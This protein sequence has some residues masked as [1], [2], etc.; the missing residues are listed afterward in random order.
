MPRF[1][2]VCIGILV[3]F[4]AAMAGCSRSSLDVETPR[5]A[6]YI[7][8]S[9]SVSGDGTE[10]SPFRN[11]SEVSA[12]NAGYSYLQ[13]RGTIAREQIVITASGTSGS[14]ITLGA[15][16]EGAAPVI[17]G[18][19]V[20]TGWTLH[21]GAIY[22][23][24]MTLNSGEGLGMVAQDGTMITRQEWNTDVATTFAAAAAGSYSYDPATNT[25]YIWC[26]GVADPASHTIEISRRLF[27]VRGV[28]VSYINVENLH[29]RYT[30]LHGIVF[31]NGTHINVSGCTVE[32]LGGA[33]IV[34]SP[35]L[36]AGN[37]IEFGNSSAHCTVTGCAI[38]DIFDSGISPQTYSSNHHASD[39]T[40]SDSTISRCGFAGVEIAVLYNG[41]MVNS[42]IDGVIVRNVTVLDSGKGWSGRRYGVE[43]RGIKINADLVAGDSTRG[44]SGVVVE[45]STVSGSAGEG[46]FI[47]GRAGMVT[48]RRCTVRDNGGIGVL[49]QESLITNLLLDLYSSVIR[50]NGTAPHGCGVAYNVPAGQGIVV[51]QNSFYDNNNIGLNIWSHD[52]EARIMNN[53]FHASAYRTHLLVNDDI[54]AT[55][56]IS[57]NCF[58]EFGAGQPIFNY[59]GSTYDTVAA[60]DTA[61]SA[62]AAGDIGTS[63]PLLNAD[64]TIQGMGSPCYHAGNAAAGIALDRNGTP[65]SNPPSIGA[66]EY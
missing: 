40:F 39:F 38:S 18:S 9:A 59:T 28:G 46:I 23:K 2:P 26:T 22:Q 52:G 54:S 60:F 6:V 7:D 33:V 65:F 37:G 51:R 11:W 49:A 13:K 20:E 19:E 58:T 3:F 57:N 12:M 44:V 64:F 34:P 21:S 16:G 10:S 43:G 55:A 24:I 61:Y 27:G 63:D 15:Y 47:G 17:L 25:V 35:V 4:I 50:N 31:E 66:Y 14:P 8:P 29:I 5:P 30:S 1:H 42:D 41:G 56:V 45:N 53:V 48:V 32:K 36:Y 62:F